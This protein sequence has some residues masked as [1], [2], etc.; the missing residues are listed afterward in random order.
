MKFSDYFNLKFFKLAVTT[1]GV[2]AVLLL[3]FRAGEFVGFHKA[4]FSNRWADNYGRNFGGM[5]GMFRDFDDQSALNPHGT[6]GV[7]LKIDGDTLTVKDQNNTEKTVVMSTS[8]ILREH[9]NTMQRSDLKVDDRLTVIGAPNDQ[10]QVEA[11]F[12]RIFP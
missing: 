12:I 2:L 3:V 8:T 5:R 10:G 7:I 4:G 11:K 6:V 9:M 1:L